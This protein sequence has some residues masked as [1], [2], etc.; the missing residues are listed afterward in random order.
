MSEEPFNEKDAVYDHPTPIDQPGTLHRALESISVLRNR[1]FNVVVLAC[2]T[3]PD[4]YELVEGKVN[5]LVTPFRNYFPVS[6]VSHS[7]EARLK[8]RLEQESKAGGGKIEGGLVSLTGYSNI[9]NMCLIATELARSEVAVLLDDDEVYE[10]PDYLDKVFENIGT[11]YEG[12][13][14][15]TLAGYYQRPDGSY[16]LPPPEEWWMSEWPMVSAM[17]EAFAIIEQEPRLKPTTWVFGGNMVIHRDIFRKISFDPHVRRGED[18][19]YLVNCKFFDIDFLLDNQLAIKH[20]P[21]T[22]HVPA[23]AH[24]RENIYRFIYAREKLLR[25]V[26]AEG[27]RRVEAEE[28][29]PYPGRCMRD[30]LEDM[31]FKTSVLM[32]L[33]QLRR[34]GDR[35]LLTPAIDIGFEESM[36]NIHIARFDATPKHD[37]FLWYLDFRAKWEGLMEFL[38]RDEALAK[39]IQSAF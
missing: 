29:N 38:T 16:L 30:D 14:V 34:P 25:Q 33:H 11:T 27:V 22:T 32:G 21:P 9:R 12:K 7:F 18:I 20:M 15:G 2:A 36:K 17:N 26:P 6:V 19:D 39:D 8:D 13:F 1:D 5:D 31:I 37:P 23:W 10:D 24:F 35:S 4:I 3:A 28:L